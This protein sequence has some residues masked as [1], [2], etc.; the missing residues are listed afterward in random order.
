MRFVNSWV[1]RTHCH[2]II[3]LSDA[4]QDFPRS[5]TVN[6]HGVSPVFLEVGRRKAFATAAATAAENDPDSAAAS[7][8]G[9]TVNNMIRSFGAKRDRRRSEERAREGKPPPAPEPEKIRP[10]TEVFS[11]G[12]YFLGKVVWGK[13]FNELLR[14]VEEH[15]TSEAGSR[16][17][18]SWTSLAP[19]RTLTTSRRARGRRACRSS[20][21]AAWTTLRVYARL[22]GVHKP[23]PV[24]RR[25]HHH[26]GGFGDGKVRHLREA[27]EQRVLLDVSKLHGVREPRAIFSVR[28][29][30]SE[31]RSHA[32]QRQGQVQAVVG[33][34]HGQVPDAA[35]IKEEQM[36]G[37]GT[38]LGDKLGETLF[39]AVHRAAAKHEKMRGVLGAGQGTGRG[40][41]AGELGTWGG[42]PSQ[43]DQQGFTSTRKK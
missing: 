26:R 29:E 11:K 24:R 39:A 25:R 12:C 35:D 21:R 38:G 33:G 28:E 5:E 3:K 2:K 19:A 42:V 22:Q 36:R 4:V 8:M 37:P 17:L 27:S 14:R 20:S 6:I 16:T 18:S 10:S 32:A 34:G 43:R 1:S 23:V 31:H 15:N 9:R 7:A 13:G 41:K 40:P 30:G